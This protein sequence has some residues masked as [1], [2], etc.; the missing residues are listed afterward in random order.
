ML[1]AAGVVFAGVGALRLELGRVE[2]PAFVAEGLELELSADGPAVLRVARLEA[3]GG[4]WRDAVLRCA[5][6]ALQRDLVRCGRGVLEIPG[7]IERASVDLRLDRMAGSGEMDIR[8]T[9]G[10]AVAV[11]MQRDGGFSLR[12]DDVDLARLARLIPALA[13]WHTVGRLDADVRYAAQPARLDAT[14]RLAG[15]GVS[16]GDGLQAAENL[17]VEASLQATRDGAD[18]NWQGRAAWTG[19]E[20]YVHPVY[21]SAGPSISATGGYRSGML[22]IAHADVDVEGV[23]AMALAAEFD[24]RDGHLRQLALSAADAE[25][26]VVGPRFLAPLLAPAHA[27]ELRFDGYLSAGIEIRGGALEAFDLAFDEAAVE[28]AAKAIALGPFS[29]VIPWRAGAATEGAVDVAGM[30]WQKLAPGPFSLSAQFDGDRVVLR[31]VAIPILDGAFVLEGFE[32]HR[33]ERGW[34]G[35]GAAAVQ[36]VSMQRLT[37]A[38]GLP[39]MSGQLSASLPGIRLGPGEIALDGALVISVFDG[40]VRASRLQVLEPFGVA[41]RLYADVDARHLD[42]A[43]MTETFSFGSMTGFVDADVVGLELVRWRPV[44]FTADLRSSPGSYRKRISQRAVENL[45]ALG[46]A[47]AVAALQR[48]FLHFFSSFGYSEIGVSC[49]LRNGVCEMGGLGERARGS[50]GYYLVRGGGIPS[51]NV[52][53]YNRRVDWNELIDRLK[54]VVAANAAPVID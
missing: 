44:A 35:C 50:D 17:A 39:A 46:G 3:G 48:G 13:P 47:G 25:L 11:R 37:E 54:R 36:P 12:L 23:R 15:A 51:L 5:T 4:I 43:Q 9:A 20:A 33:T 21:L 24:A 14:G 29:G 22:K 7:L 52:I 49:V 31:P 40:Y 18:W 8:T 41:P 16:S 26:A 1:F 42:L 6:F 34:E 45:T 19:G 27:D 53:G 28:Y 30:R 38:I 10:E 32:L 2:H